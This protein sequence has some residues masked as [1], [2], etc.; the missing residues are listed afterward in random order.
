MSRNLLIG[1]T[2]LTETKLL[3]VREKN[4]VTLPKEV[5]QSFQMRSPGHLQYIIM[6]DGVL[7]RPVSAPAE[8]KLAKIRRLAGSVHS[9]YGGVD[10]AAA[11][12]NQ[13]RNAW[14]A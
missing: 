3:R 1:L 14:A 8:D 4:Q 6:Q 9:A 13:Q 7:I 11:F 10:E 2:M 12:I 5:M